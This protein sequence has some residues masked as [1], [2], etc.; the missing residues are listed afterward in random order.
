MS[1]TFGR[2][3]KMNEAGLERGGASYFAPVSGGSVLVHAIID[4]KVSVFEDGTFVRSRQ[5]FDDNTPVVLLDLGS[6]RGLVAFFI[7]RSKMGH[8][9]KDKAPGSGLRIR[10]D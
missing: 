1:I 10:H 2:L 6:V 5:V 7:G 3:M 8:R 4:G 9:I